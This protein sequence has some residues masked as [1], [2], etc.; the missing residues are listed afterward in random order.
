MARRPRQ[1]WTRRGSGTDLRYDDDIIPSRPTNDEL[2]VSDEGSFDGNYDA[3]HLEISSPSN[4]QGTV[5][6]IT[7]GTL[8]VPHSQSEMISDKIAEQYEIDTEI[9]RVQRQVV[10]GPVDTLWARRMRVHRFHIQPVQSQRLLQVNHFRRYFTIMV[11]LLDA[12]AAAATIA[13]SDQ[14]I[15][16]AG[17]TVPDNCFAVVGFTGQVLSYGPFFH[18]GELW[19]M[20]TSAATP[21]LSVIEYFGQ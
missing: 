6:T 10:P 4:V 8:S 16:T 20:C 9:A 19:G 11:D 14:P 12:A 13:L 1:A 21:A 3:E 5:D 2:P 15:N 7:E 18:Q 17:L